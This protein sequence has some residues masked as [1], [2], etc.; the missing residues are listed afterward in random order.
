MPPRI[1]PNHYW[2]VGRAAALFTYA[3]ALLENESDEI[4]Q[5]ELYQEINAELTDGFDKLHER[6]TE[7]NPRYHVKYVWGNIQDCEDAH[8]GDAKL[9]EHFKGSGDLEFSDD[10]EDYYGS[11]NR[12][13]WASPG[14][15]ILTF[16]FCYT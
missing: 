15:Y 14:R 10:D 6:Y 9:M 7:E 3:W 1:D 11:V 12:G 5:T 13:R 16:C 4:K 8:P 2:S